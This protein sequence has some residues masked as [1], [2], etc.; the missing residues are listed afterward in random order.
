[1][2]KSLIIGLGN[3]IMG[4]DAIGCKCAEAIQAEISPSDLE[5]IE[6][7]LFFRGG[8][9]LMERMIGYDRVLIIDSISGTGPKPGTITALTLAEVPSYTVNS[10]H[11]GSLK[12]A[13]DFGLTIGVH[14][15]DQV[16]ILAVEIEPKFEFSEQLSI[17]VNES[18][19]Q[20]LKMT[21]D[22]I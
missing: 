6:V 17:P 15:P 14:L 3:P 2:M 18:I 21:R 16:D 10:P 19:A 5:G 8:I 4:D 9:S 11:D 7:D 1:M 13:I 22:W 12:N 20:V